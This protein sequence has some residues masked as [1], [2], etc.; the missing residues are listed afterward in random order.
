MDKNKEMKVKK[1]LQQHKQ[2]G[3]ITKK[4]YKK[5]LEFIKMLKQKT[6]GESK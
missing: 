2:K 3:I 6:D 5:E 4:Q 1:I